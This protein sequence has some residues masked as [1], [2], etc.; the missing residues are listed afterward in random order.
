MKQFKAIDE[1]VANVSEG[2]P[3]ETKEEMI[4]LPHC[5]MCQSPEEYKKFFIKEFKYWRVKLHENQVL[6]WE[7]HCGA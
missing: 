1:Y 7:V 2:C 6:P 5:S 4:R 3:G